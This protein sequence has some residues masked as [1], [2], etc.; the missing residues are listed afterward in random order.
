[1]QDIKEL[2]P[3]ELEEV[4]KGWGQSRFHVRQILS[5]IYK[6]GVK[7]FSQMTDVSADLRNRLKANFYLCGLNLVKTLKSRDGTTKFL[8][9]LED[10]NLIEAVIIPAQARITG[11]VSTQAGCK[12]ACRFCASGLAGFKRNLTAEEMLDE[13]LYLKDNS[14]DKRLTHLVFMGLGEPLD[15]YDN[16]IKAIRTI[17]SSDGLNIG[18]RRI[19]VSTCGLIPQ[20]KKLADENLQ[21]ELSVSLHSANDRTRSEIMPINKKHPLKELILACRDYIK[22]TNRQVTFE[23]ILI[24]GLNSDL[25]SALDL[26]NILKG[27]KLC[28]VNII[29]ANPIRE[30]SVEPPNKLEILLFRNCLLKHGLDATLRK[31]RGQDIEAACGQLRLRYENK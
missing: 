16:V 19:T 25:Q 29:P 9:A 28:K 22:K 21:I 30:C 11:C 2:S 1:M 6:K 20:I 26:S 18:A 14:E 7:D 17:N 5:W 10:K 12:F 24:K 13:V 15:N 27:L 3:E 4:F 31:L 8:L 23:Y